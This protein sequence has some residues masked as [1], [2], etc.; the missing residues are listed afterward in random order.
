M[1]FI[2]LQ[3]NTTNP[4][5]PTTNKVRLFV[6][7]D[8]I[9]RSI[10]NAGVVTVYG[11]SN[12]LGSFAQYT[13]TSTFTSS[14]TS[15]VNIPIAN[16]EDSNLGSSFSKPSANIIQADIT[17]FLTISY[18]VQGYPDSN[19][20]GFRCIVRRNGTN[21]SFTER[22]A[23]TKDDQERQTTASLTFFESCTSGDQFS[24]AIVSPEGATITVEPER[25]MLALS[26]KS[27]T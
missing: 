24:L 20:R 26:I 3:E 8:G 27:I 5:A 14:S 17:G 9:L 21:L 18:S 23:S 2:C 11:S 22:S 12:V 10:D 7:D 1:S 15:Y 19:D 4:T 25:A 16:D 6:G 13:N